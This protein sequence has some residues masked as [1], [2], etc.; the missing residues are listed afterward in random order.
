MGFLVHSVRTVKPPRQPLEA[1]TIALKDLRI[2]PVDR[3]GLCYRRSALFGFNRRSRVSVSCPWSGDARPLWRAFGYR[4]VVT[5]PFIN[6]LAVRASTALHHP[7]VLKRPENLVHRLQ[8]EIP[9]RAAI[10][11]SSRGSGLTRIAAATRSRLLSTDLS[12]SV[13]SLTDSPRWRPVCPAG[14]GSGADV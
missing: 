3:P 11:S 5:E 8:G 12:G 9:V 2:E 10:W 7:G 14:R 1:L 6:D 13:S 4:V